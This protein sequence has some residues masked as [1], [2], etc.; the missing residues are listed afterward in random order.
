MSFRHRLALFLV[1]TLIG[2]Q[3]LTAILAYGVVRRN[4]VQQATEELEA[5]IGAFA[6]Q[7]DVYSQSLVDD[8]TVLSLDYGLR[9][10]VAEADAATTLSVLTN[11]G[12]R[13]GASRMILVDLE[14]NI[15]TDTTNYGAMGTRFPFSGLLAEAAVEDQ[16]VALAALDGEIYWIVVAPVKAPVP[17]AFIAA[18]VPIDGPLLARIGS[19]SAT[20]HSLSLAT[21]DERGSW[22]LVDNSGN[23]A[24]PLPEIEQIPAENAI[25]ATEDGDRLAMTSRLPT[26]E[27]SAPV[28][29]ILDYPLDELLSGYRAILAPFLVVLAGALAIAL[30]GAMLIARSVSKPLE[31]LAGAAQR[32]ASGDYRSVPEIRR[33]DEIGELSRA[34]ENMSQ[35]IAE[36]ENALMGAVASLEIARDEAV[37]ANEAKTQFLSNMSHELRT[38]LNA[39]LGFAE[40]I[41]DEAIGP[42]GRKQYAE[43]AAHIHESGENLLAQLTAMLDLAESAAGKMVLSRETVTI[44]AMLRAIIEAL[45]PMAAKAGVRVQIEPRIAELPPIEADTEKLRQSL[46]NLVHNA[47]K[48]SPGGGRVGIDGAVKG[49]SLVLRVSDHG[50]GI[51]ADDIPVV[52]RPFHR[53]RTAFDGTHQGAGIGLP[54]AKTV[55]ELH[56]GELEIES[57]LDVGT[58]IVVR[59]PLAGAKASRNIEDAA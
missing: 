31:A 18:G 10:A 52:T 32:I 19:L 38:P 3:A 39:I 12:R 20:P 34:L 58:T 45:A 44:Y 25:L 24:P 14:G 59:L 2:V 8:V 16:A 57:T 22:T 23:A 28:F 40:M 6:R 55:I 5:A 4:L 27:N 50:S 54:F 17:I 48:F 49:N 7:L 21:V 36:R 47:I 1:V 33:R 51:P 53:R 29:A 41:R 35:S 42:V 43:Y 13:I 46:A 56:G 26:A 9:S 30:F 37:R 15:T 11:H